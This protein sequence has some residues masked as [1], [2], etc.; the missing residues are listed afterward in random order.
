MCQITYPNPI[1]ELFEDDAII[2]PEMPELTDDEMPEL[3]DDEMPDDAMP[4][5]VFEDENPAQDNDNDVEP[6]EDHHVIAEI[7]ANIYRTHFFERGMLFESE[8]RQ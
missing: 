7:F 1:Y 2:D 8:P 5:L 6:E 3:T 4:E